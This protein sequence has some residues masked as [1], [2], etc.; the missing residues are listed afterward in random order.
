MNSMFVMPSVYATIKGAQMIL[1]ANR[2]V[3]WVKRLPVERLVMFDLSD[4]ISW[5]ILLLVGLV[6]L[7]LIIRRLYH[8]RLIRTMSKEGKVRKLNA[9]LN[10]FGFEYDDKD[11]VFVSRIDAWQRKAGYQ[12]AYD[13]LAIGAN[14][15]IEAMPVYFD[16][17]GKTWLIECW[18][19]QYGIT[20][21]NEIGL[22]HADSIVDPKDYAKTNFKVV[23]DKEMLYLESKL[24]LEGEQLFF[25]RRWH[26]WLASFGLGK[27]KLPSECKSV[28][29][30]HFK[31]AAMKEA[32]LEGAE[33]YMVESMRA[34]S[35]SRNRVVLLWKESL[36]RK[37][38]FHARIVNHVNGIW[39]RLFSWYTRPFHSPENQA[40]FLYMQ[41]PFLKF[42]FPGRKSSSAKRRKSLGCK[43]IK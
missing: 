16:Y 28:F 10:P 22:Y 36:N 1:R 35:F 43:V 4:Y 30:I 33:N 2:L 3:V 7:G 8:I 13:V 41:I 29:I 15:I 17:D 31:D 6:A 42:L 18:R 5:G 21:G 11:K 12:F 24:I 38:G 23:S 39:I 14:M 9:L 27:H 25:Q 26:W 20:V 19:G 40:L 34:Y 37:L 32:F